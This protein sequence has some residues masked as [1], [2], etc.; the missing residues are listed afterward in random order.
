MKIALEY[1]LWIRKVRS[2]KLYLAYGY[3]YSV[4]QGKMQRCDGVKV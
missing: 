4:N 2:N 3:S 1:T